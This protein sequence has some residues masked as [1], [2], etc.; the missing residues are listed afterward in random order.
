MDH[1][2]EKSLKELNEYISRLEEYALIG[3]MGHSLTHGFNAGTSS[4]SYQIESLPE[5]YDNIK[6]LYQSTMGQVRSVLNTCYH[7]KST[8]R[9]II[10]K[11]DFEKMFISDK[12]EFECEDDVEVFN[13][14]AVLFAIIHELL[15]NAF[16]YRNDRE[17]K[18]QLVINNSRIYVRNPCDTPKNIDRLF[19]LEYVD[20]TK[21]NPGSG[22]GLYFSK[23]M[24]EKINCNLRV[25][26][27]RGLSRITFY[28]DLKKKQ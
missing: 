25:S 8:Y 24:A 28:L 9:Q 13:D 23:K 1:I 14:K 4:L 5:E 19:D 2:I 16:K 3:M 18:P 11:E 20:D 17:S 15:N 7:K 12:I 26:Y 6:K 21:P 27:S 10:K 22:F